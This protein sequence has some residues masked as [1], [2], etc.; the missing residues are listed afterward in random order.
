MVPPVTLAHLHARHRW[1]VPMAATAFAV[2]AVGAA[3]E[4]LPWD[5][6]IT[7]MVVEART[8]T[9]ES[10]ARRV[11]F[12]GSTPVVLVVAGVAA[13]AAWRRSPRLAVAIVLIALARPLAE[14]GLKELVGRE[15][16]VGHRLVKGTGPSFPSGHPLAA[17]ASWCLLPL[18]VELYARRRAVWWA[19]V[20]AVWTLAVC[21]GVSRV[22]LG[23]HWASDVVGGL[24]LAV[25]GVAAAERIMHD[26]A[27]RRTHVAPP[28]G[29]LAGRRHLVALAS[30]NAPPRSTE[31]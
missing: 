17:S 10:W 3:Y 4:L 25:L 15:R 31:T 27:S 13:L 28:E 26:T 29:R 5:R 19:T 11:S 9:S 14:W 30:G 7:R 18:V 21:V 20:V 16:P 12:L 1:I 23:V 2:L 22:W 6:P 8:P 24:L